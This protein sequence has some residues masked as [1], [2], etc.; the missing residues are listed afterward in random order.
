MFW[1]LLNMLASP[2]FSTQMR[3]T[4]RRIESQGFEL[5]IQKA[6]LVSKNIPA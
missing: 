4:H 6:V 1:S 2:S 3:N 5:F